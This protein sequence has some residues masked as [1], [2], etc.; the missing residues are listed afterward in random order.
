L[1]TSEIEEVQLDKHMNEIEKQQ[2]QDYAG[3]VISYMEENGRNTYP[4]KKVYILDFFF[5][6]IFE[7]LI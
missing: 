2:F 4:L 7:I 5:L 1:K 3:R 6:Q